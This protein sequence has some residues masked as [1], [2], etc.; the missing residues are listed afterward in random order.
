MNLAMCV[1]V[2]VERVCVREVFRGGSGCYFFGLYTRSER[3]IEAVTRNCESAPNFAST[4]VGSRSA[5]TSSRVL[6]VYTLFCVQKRQIN[7]QKNNKQEIGTLETRNKRH[8][9]RT[10]ARS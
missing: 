10:H 6:G 9:V 8:H 7:K 5:T 2:R 4:A 1:C 3:S